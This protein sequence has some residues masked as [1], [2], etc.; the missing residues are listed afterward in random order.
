MSDPRFTDPQGTDPRLSDPVM[1]QDEPGGSIWGW[2][3]G[4]AVL[5]LVAFIVVAGWNSNSAS[6]ASNN[7]PP[8]STSGSGASTPMMPSAPAPSRAPA[9]SPNGGR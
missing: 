1:R 8:A 9:Q 2:V 7:P 5:A 6:T 3:A 4:L